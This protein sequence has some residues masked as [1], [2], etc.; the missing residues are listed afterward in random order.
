MSVQVAAPLA[1]PL[2]GGGF[3]VCDTMM[4]RL[5]RASDES[6]VWQQLAVVP[7]MLLS[8]VNN[9]FRPDSPLLAD[10]DY[11]SYIRVILPGSHLLPDHD[12]GRGDLDDANLGRA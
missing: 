12:C 1:I 3:F 11:V 2:K 5:F 7:V 6:D 10:I 4:G 8:T 9:S